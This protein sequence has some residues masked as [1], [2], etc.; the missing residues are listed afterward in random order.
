ML[1]G[2]VEEGEYQDYGTIR[3]QGIETLLHKMPPPSIIFVACL[4]HQSETY[5]NYYCS[6]EKILRGLY[7][8]AALQDITE[9]RVGLGGRCE[10]SL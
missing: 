6:Q 10:V 3:T 2:P 5:V 7:E 1:D 9:Y 8:L 4:L